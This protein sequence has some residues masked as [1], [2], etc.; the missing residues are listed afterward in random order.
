M[1]RGES[2]KNVE[3]I[4]LLKTIKETLEKGGEWPPF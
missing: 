2:L 3:F 1:F 4:F